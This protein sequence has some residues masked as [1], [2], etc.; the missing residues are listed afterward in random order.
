MAATLLTG[1][2]LGRTRF[3]HQELLKALRL[4]D[5]AVSWIHAK[6]MRR[7]SHEAHQRAGLE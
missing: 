5:E 6:L 2:I 4:S 1:A 3:E 7:Q